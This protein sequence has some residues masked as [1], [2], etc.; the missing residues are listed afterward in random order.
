MPVLLLAASCV[1]AN[2]PKNDWHNTTLSDATIKKIQQA[3]YTY[4]KCVASQMKTYI[5]I[6][7]DIRVSTDTIIKNCE[8]VLSGMRDVYKK[9]KVPATIINRH[10]K[11]MRV[12]T[13][14]DVLKQLM[15]ADAARKAGE[16]KKPEKNNE[17]K[18]FH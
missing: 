10:M 2:D 17:P 13:A 4:K 11:Q 1:F 6:K 3:Q 8:N 9:E 14:R 18:L 7:Q 5:H 15:F 16:F 12:K